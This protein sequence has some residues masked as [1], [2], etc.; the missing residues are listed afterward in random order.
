MVS[1]WIVKNYLHNGVVRMSSGI[2]YYLPTSVIV[3]KAELGEVI[4]RPSKQRVWDLWLKTPRGC[5]VVLIRAI[6]AFFQTPALTCLW[7]THFVGGEQ[8]PTVCA[9]TSPHYYSKVGNHVQY[10]MCGLTHMYSFLEINRQCL[11]RV[12]TGLILQS[13]G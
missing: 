2:K 13:S 9:H 1:L 5:G 12:I 6:R 10:T 8:V 7:A 4:Y 11:L 3:M